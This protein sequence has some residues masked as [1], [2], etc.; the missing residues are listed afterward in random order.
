MKKIGLTGGI[1]SGKTTISK[2][3]QMLGTPIYN[4]DEAA[5]KILKNNSLAKNQIL[6]YFGQKVLTNNKFDNKKLLILFL[7][8]KKN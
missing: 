3:F 1:G 6:Q 5:K 2:I 7:N 4:S 8:K